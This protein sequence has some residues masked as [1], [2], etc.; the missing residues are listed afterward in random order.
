MLAH[1]LANP[2]EPLREWLRTFFCMNR[3]ALFCPFGQFDASKA[4][5]RWFSDFLR[6]QVA[7][8]EALGMLRH[9]VVA[10]VAELA[11]AL[12]S[13]PSGGKTPWRFDSSQPHLVRNVCMLYSCSACTAREDARL[14]V[15]PM[16][17]TTEAW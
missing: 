4:F 2:A 9:C 17:M 16:R 5:V 8:S 3:S 6:M 10:A 1:R 11:D 15:R 13:G 14:V 12:G 7:R